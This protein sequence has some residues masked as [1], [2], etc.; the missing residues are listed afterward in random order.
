[1]GMYV[2]I[3]LISPQVDIYTHTYTQSYYNIVY[4]LFK[5]FF[6]KKHISRKSFVLEFLYVLLNFYFF[7][8]LFIY[9]GV[10]CHLPLLYVIMG[11]L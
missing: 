8:C 5:P 9:V 2:R 10:I 1:M 3:W 7:V 4:I 6:R 11:V